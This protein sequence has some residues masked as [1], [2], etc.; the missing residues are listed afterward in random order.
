[1]FQTTVAAETPSQ[2]PTGT[3]PS[4]NLP[5]SFKI[6]CSKSRIIYSEFYI[7][8][9][10]NQKLH[11]ISTRYKFWSKLTIGLHQG[12]SVD[13]PAL[14]SAFLKNGSIKLN[15]ASGRDAPA[16][17]STGSSDLAFDLPVEGIPAPEHFEW[18]RSDGP[19]V[20]SLSGRGKGGWVL[21]R[22]SHGAELGEPVAAY[23]V[24]LTSVKHSGDF[25][26]FN[27]GRTGKLGADFAVLAVVTALVLGQRKRSN[28]NNLVAFTVAIT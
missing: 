24:D 14:G 26:F 17:T 20:A 3:H 2:L 11:A 8:H 15:L 16:P 23:S 6:Y 25:A 13:S 12:P 4:I 19:E 7:A 22:V 9:E 10:K 1:M 21:L 28:M 18:R 27:S 5:L